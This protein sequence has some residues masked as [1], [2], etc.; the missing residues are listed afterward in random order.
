[1]NKEKFSPNLSLEEREKKLLAMSD[2]EIDYSDIPPL[3]DEF[4]KNTKLVNKKS[5]EKLKN[6]T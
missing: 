5:R 2:D 6:E 3:D 1:M 4:F